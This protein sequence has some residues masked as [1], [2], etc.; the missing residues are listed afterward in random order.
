MALTMDEIK[1]RY[2]KL[3]LE[4]GNAV[5]A[6]FGKRGMT[7]KRLVVQAN[8]YAFDKRLKT[9]G[10]FR[11]HALAFAYAL[12]LRVEK[13]YSTFLRKLF[14]IFAFLGLL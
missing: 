9:D 7:S 1:N 3:V 11:F 6:S 2:Y 8:T 12:G 10:V 5:Y 13:R 14:R 4:K